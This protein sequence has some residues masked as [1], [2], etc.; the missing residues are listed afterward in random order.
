MTFGM[1]G[2]L[3]GRDLASSVTRAALR[4][5]DPAVTCGGIGKITVANMK[6]PRISGAFR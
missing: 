6:K 2:A 4:M 5:P 1:A 3:R